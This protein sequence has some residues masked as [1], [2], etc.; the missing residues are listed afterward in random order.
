MVTIPSAAS[1]PVMALTR[2]LE[3]ATPRTGAAQAAP[4]PDP[5]SERQLGKPT[6]NIVSTGHAWKSLIFVLFVVLTVVATTHCFFQLLR[7]LNDDSVKD[8]VKFLL[9][10]AF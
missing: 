4:E 1:A 2:A 7:L 5:E 8:V 9:R 3:T 10:R 6:S